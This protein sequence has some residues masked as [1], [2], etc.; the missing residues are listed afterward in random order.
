MLIFFLSQINKLIGVKK[1]MERIE[2]ENTLVLLHGDEM[3]QVAFDALIK[4]FINKYLKIGLFEVDLSAKNR[5]RTGGEVV[6]EAIDALISYKVGVKNAGITVNKQQ[7]ESFLKELKK[8][9]IQLTIG[10]LPKLAIKSPNGAIRKGIHG[11]I[12]REDIPFVN[13]KRNLPDWINRDI[14]VMTMEDGGLINSFNQ[15]LQHSGIL[16]VL[17][18]DK[19]GRTRTLHSRAVNAGDP[20]LLCSNAL[21]KVE[22]FA[23]KIFQRALDESKDVYVGLKDTVMPGYDGA[24]RDAVDRV[25]E[26]SFKDAFKRQKLS[27]M[28]G[29]ID[30][31]AAHIIAHPPKKALWGI[32]DNT[33]G[34]KMYKLVESL[35]KF[36]IPQRDHKVAIS[37]MSAGGG[38]QYGSFNHQ[39]EDDGFVTIYVGNRALHARDVKK[40][41]PIMLMSNKPCAIKNWVKQTFD[42]AAQ[43][44]QEIYFGLKRE[45]ME[46]D[47]CFSDIV[48][49]VRDELAEGGKTPPPV[50]MMTPSKQLRK[51]ICDPPRNAH[52]AALNLDGDIFSDITAALGGSLA[53]AS[54][55]ILSHEGI[56]LFEAPHG[57]APDLYDTYLKSDGKEAWFNPSALYYALANALE[58]IAQSEKNESLK[59][60]SEAMKDALIKVVAS[61]IITPDIK[62]MITNIDQQK[63]VDLFTFIDAIDQHLSNTLSTSKY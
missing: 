57:T 1:Q 5:L 21:E 13:L 39:M 36:G 6:Q 3:A 7:L 44:D 43:K 16:K 12:T 42:E 53:T 20:W 33:S 58:V 56:N 47:Q 18:T 31:Q 62:G 61:G 41:D 45:Y 34:R 10:G 48:N 27:Y 38:D 51:M 14:E 24:M 17:F 8:E 28:Y 29:L 30:A 54:S 50:M 40:G 11:N 4:R 9:N 49:E 32:P 19:A 46:Y 37:R 52:Y 35:K 15:V 63:V 25:F 23:H 2:V 59:Q 22:A 60:F 26:Q 55:I